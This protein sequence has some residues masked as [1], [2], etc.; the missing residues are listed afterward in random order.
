[1]NVTGVVIE[2]A[3]RKLL[4]PLEGGGWNVTDLGRPS[5]PSIQAPTGG[6]SPM[7]FL[8]GVMETRGETPPPD[9]PDELAPRGLGVWRGR[10]Q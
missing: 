4:L 2:E 9:A 7:T 6:L 8:V 10:R 5:R 1:M 3:N